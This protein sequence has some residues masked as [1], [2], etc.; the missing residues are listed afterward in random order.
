MKAIDKDGN[1]SLVA[2]Y[3]HALLC[4]QKGRDMY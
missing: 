2:A 3:V 1:E 4:L